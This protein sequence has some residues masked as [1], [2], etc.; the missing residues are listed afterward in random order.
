MSQ[1]INPTPPATTEPMG[2]FCQSCAMP[3]GKPQ[4]FGTEANGIRSNDYCSY[5]YQQGK[6]TAPE[7]TMEQMRDFCVEKMVELQVMPRAEATTLMRDTMPSLKRWA[8]P[9]RRT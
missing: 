3:L 9:P 7:M 4:D 1:T 5:C 2:P 8:G 6:F